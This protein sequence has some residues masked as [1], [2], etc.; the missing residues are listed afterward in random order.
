MPKEKCATFTYTDK[1]TKYITKISKHTNTN[2]AY[3][4]HNTMQ[5]NF[6]P[7]THNNGNFSATG[8]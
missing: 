7:K 1:E 5:E 4:T 3:R 8:V 2:I 6:T